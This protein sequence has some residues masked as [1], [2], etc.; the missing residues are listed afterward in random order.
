MDHRGLAHAFRRVASLERAYQ[1]PAAPRTGPLHHGLR[2]RRHIGHLEGEAAQRVAVERV[3]AGRDQHQ[4]RRPACG[5]GVHRAEKRVHVCGGGQSA[6][7]GDVPDGLLGAA[8]VRR[9][10]ARI[11]RPLV[12]RDK[13][14]IL[15]VLHERLRA[16]A[17][18]HVPVG[19]ENA[20]HPVARARVVRADGHVAENAESHGVIAQCV[21]ARRAHRAI[22]PAPIGD[23]EV[24]AVEHTPRPRPCG[25]PRAVAR[26]GVGVKPA[27]AALRH[28][29]HRL[30]VRRIVRQ[31]NLVGG[32]VPPFAMFDAEHQ[33]PVVAQRPR[34][35]AQP[36]DM[37]GMVPPGVVPPAVGVRDEGDAHAWLAWLARLAQL[38]RR[39]PAS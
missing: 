22:R 39:A 30:H 26:H 6:R 14:D 8:V 5:G 2:E 32:G 29:A 19:D 16:V 10:R 20:F 38:T 27:A 12:H 34:D 11:P 33:L 4:I 37:F 15:G 17:V 1:T 23:R 24:N 3:K 25:V 18:V 36:P 31:R 13:A 21:V 7:Q 28:G 9:A 35:G